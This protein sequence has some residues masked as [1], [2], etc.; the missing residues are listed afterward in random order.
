MTI[1]SKVTDDNFGAKRQDKSDIPTLLVNNHPI[2]GAKGKANALNNHFKSVF[3]KENLS[4]IPTMDN[5]TDI[6]DMPDI[7]ISEATT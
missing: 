5:H 7:I 6:A 1:P 2:H 3:T 4:S